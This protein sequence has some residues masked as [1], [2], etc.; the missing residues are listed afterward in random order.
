M[1]KFIST[2]LIGSLITTAVIGV[3]VK[4]TVIKT[5]GYSIRQEKVVNSKVS[6]KKDVNVAKRVTMVNTENKKIKDEIKKDVDAQKKQL[7][8][9]NKARRDKFIKDSKNKKGK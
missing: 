7:A 5:D 6:V 9:E 8:K 4:K 1:K 2:L 3:S